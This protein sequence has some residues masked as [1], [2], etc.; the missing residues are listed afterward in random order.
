MDSCQ[1]KIRSIYTSHFPKYVF[2]LSWPKFFFLSFRQFRRSVKFVWRLTVD[3]W[4]TQIAFSKK[5][6][7]VY[8]VETKHIFR[9]SSALPIK[10]FCNAFLNFF[11]R[12]FRSSTTS[13]RFASDSNKTHIWIPQCILKQKIISVMHF[14][15]WSILKKSVCIY[16][17]SYT[18]KFGTSVKSTFFSI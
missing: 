13:K 5:T 6:I 10:K 9:L 8:D 12:Q 15:I 14:L 4:R 7:N 18:Y 17:W 1:A 11:I 2:R 16:F 3:D